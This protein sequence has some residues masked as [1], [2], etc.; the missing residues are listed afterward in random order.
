MPPDRIQLGR[1]FSL[2]IGGARSGKSDIAVELGKAWTGEVMFA[3]TAEGLDDDMAD[4]I[5]RHQADRPADWGLIEAPLLN[6]GTVTEVDPAALLIIDC[7]T[8]L[9]S[10]LM[11]AEKTN[12]QLESHL[13]LLTHALVG[14][15]A[16]TRVISNEGGL[17]VRPDTE[18]GRRYRGVLGRTN[19]RLASRAE[20][21]LF[22]AAG[23]V[24]PL[25][26]LELGW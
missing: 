4:R 15:T 6:G 19:K 12:E 8:L 16:P 24:V 26:Q 20:A 13:S 23:R 11:M 9:A 18:L 14:R 21:T 25:H 3:A 7:I 2:L 10:N 17:G 5:S 22:V 1:G